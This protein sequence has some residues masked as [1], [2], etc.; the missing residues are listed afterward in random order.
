LFVP[1]HLS[2]SELSQIDAP[3]VPTEAQ[4]FAAAVIAALAVFLMLLAPVATRAAK[5][6]KGWWVEPKTWPLLCLT[7]TLIAAGYQTVSWVKQRNVPDYA[8][9]SAW[10]F[11]DLRPAFEYSFYFFIYLLAVGY[12]GFAISSFVFLQFVIWRAGLR[13]NMWRIVAALFVLALILAFR[14]GIGLWF[15]MAPIFELFPSWFVNKI[16][17]YL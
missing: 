12:L 13:T 1:A 10:A 4:G 9:K 14:V 5:I 15:P 8:R 11:G 16:A 17:I 6:D 2:M 7:V 3:E